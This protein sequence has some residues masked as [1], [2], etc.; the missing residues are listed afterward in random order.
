MSLVFFRAMGY[1]IIS[2]YILLLLFTDLHIHSINRST[3]NV[4]SWARIC[5]A[6]NLNRCVRINRLPVGYAILIRNGYDT[7]P[8]LTRV[9][10]HPDFRSHNI[11]MIFV[12][13][14]IFF[15]LKHIYLFY[16]KHYNSSVWEKK[17]LS[18]LSQTVSLRRGIDDRY[19]RVEALLRLARTRYFRSLINEKKKNTVLFI[20]KCLSIDMIDM[21]LSIK[22]YTW[23]V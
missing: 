15:K 12:V 18:H 23:S 14:G 10:S 3:L 6:R 22:I 13:F 16:W 19:V 9:K 11:Y 5:I 1:L 7:I 21:R 20:N 2:G 17:Q 4:P 8:S